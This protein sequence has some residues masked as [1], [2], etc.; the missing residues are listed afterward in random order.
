DPDQRYADAATL[1]ADLR[2]HL[3]HQPLRGVANRSLL[4]RWHKWRKRRPLAF[5]R[6]LL[7]LVMLGTVLGFAASVWLYLAERGSE[8]E[9]ALRDGQKQGQQRAYGDAVATLQHGLARVDNLPFWCELAQQLRDQLHRA[10]EAQTIAR[11]EQ[12]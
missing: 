6:V 9:R 5:R 2:R 12:L 3:T 1:A 4:E 11:R 10:E 7:G 8:A